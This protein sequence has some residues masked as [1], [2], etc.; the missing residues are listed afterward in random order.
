MPVTKRDATDD[1]NDET[2]ASKRAKITGR[3][4]R[5]SAGRR[6]LAAGFVR[7]EE[8]VTKNDD[9]DSDSESEPD[10]NGR[11]SR[12]FHKRRAP[13]PPPPELPEEPHDMPLD[14]PLTSTTSSNSNR[15]LSLTF[16]VP[17]GHQGPFVV[18]LQL[19][20]GNMDHNFGANSLSSIG[21]L[22]T[23]TSFTS[24]AI[25]PNLG[26]STQRLKRKPATFLDLPAELR[27]DIYKRA[28]INPATKDINFRFAQNFGHNSAL[29]RTCKQVYEEARQFLYG[30]HEFCFVRCDEKRGEYWQDWRS[31]W[32][33]VGWKDVRRFL[34]TIGPK[35]IAELRSIKFE[36]RDATGK[37]YR[38]GKFA[39]DDHLLEAFKL[40]AQHGALQKITL[41]IHGK[42]AI[43]EDNDRFLRNLGQIQA[44][45]VK[46]ERE[47]MQIRH[48]YHNNLGGAKI[49]SDVGK[50]LKDKMTR[51]FKLYL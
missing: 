25:V 48:Y 33:E 45:E 11:Y 16:H 29:L 34:A 20:T 24:S 51:S 8:V 22:T 40:L 35:N 2:F 10:D 17:Q 7:T 3:P 44:D 43:S 41:D 15:Q 28:I 6:S 32:E 50:K 38:T 39:S 13:S 26:R 49:R 4:T 27:N 23:A 36:F 14:A 31:E 1:L 12:L 42:A 47:E 30:E 19:P 37:E 18:N 46:I 21:A 5:Q 9:E